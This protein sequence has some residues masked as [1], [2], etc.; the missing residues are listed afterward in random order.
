MNTHDRFFAGLTSPTEI[1]AHYRTLILEAHP[2]KHPQTEFDIWNA[3]A[4]AINAQYID[5]LK[6]AD[7]YVSRGD[8][9]RDH[10]YTYRDDLE[11][12]LVNV[13]DLL[14]QQ[15]MQDVDILLVGTWIWVE[16]NTRPYKDVLGRQGLGFFW[17]AKRRVWQYHTGT[18]RTHGNTASTEWLK[19]IYGVTRITADD[20]EQ[21]PQPQQYTP[22]A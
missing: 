14:L 13:I 11:K 17:N 7:G 16:G 19:G 8:D 15:R 5:A 2:D 9:G 4:Q 20:T 18:Y 22:L 10:V 1:K 12:D 6:A 21:R 3:L